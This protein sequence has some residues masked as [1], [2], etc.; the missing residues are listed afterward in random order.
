MR[1]DTR[2]RQRQRLRRRAERMATTKEE[3]MLYT[4]LGFAWLCGL[5]FAAQW[6]ASKLQERRDRKRKGG[7]SGPDF[8]N[9]VV[10]RGGDQEI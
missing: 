1:Q 6:I 5:M 8:Q 7:A 10:R 9:Q 3:V 4:I 2:E